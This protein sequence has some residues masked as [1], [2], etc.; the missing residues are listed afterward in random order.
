M[1]V[2]MKCRSSVGIMYEQHTLSYFLLLLTT[3]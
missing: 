2:G 3:S 1:S